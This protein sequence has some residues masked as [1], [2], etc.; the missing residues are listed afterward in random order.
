MLSKFLTS[1]NPKLFAETEVAEEIR[2]S[3][4]TFS[5]ATEPSF[6]PEINKRSE[7]INRK[8]ERLPI[9]ERAAELIR[10]KEQ[11]RQE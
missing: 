5:A 6:H 10:K 4:A 9:Y 2:Q 1:N 7:Q 11:W 3:E 8:T